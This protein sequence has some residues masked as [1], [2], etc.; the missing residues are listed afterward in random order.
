MVTIQGVGG[1]PEPKSD[2]TE[3]V[4]AEREEE[5]RRATAAESADKSADD[6]AVISSEA[7]AAAEVAK[8]IRLSQSE[9][10][11]RADRIAEAKE[12][13]ERGDYKKPEEVG[14]VAERL[15]KYLT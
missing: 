14:K 6:V 10:D 5:I 7:R 9:S 15:L 2:R 13:L 3:K 4:R 1:V 8:L 11:I 12:S